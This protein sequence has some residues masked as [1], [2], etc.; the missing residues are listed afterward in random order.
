MSDHILSGDFVQKKVVCYISESW[1]SA[2][3]EVR[4][5]APLST[6]GFQVIQGNNFHEILVKDLVG[7]DYV[8]VQRDFPRN[9]AFFFDIL[10]QAREYEIPIIYEI[11]DLLFDLPDDHPDR[12]SSYYLDGLV[13]MLIAIGKAD[14]VTVSTK[15]LEKFISPFNPNTQVLQNCLADSFWHLKAPQMTEKPQDKVSIGYIG[16][17]THYPDIKMITGALTSILDQ[18]GSK[19]DL[20]FFGVTPPDEL[21]A[22]SQVDCSPPIANYREY[23]RSMLNQTIDI[24]IAPLEP[25]SFNQCKSPL[26]FLE[27]SALGVAAIFSQ[28]PPYSSLVRHEENGLL[29]YSSED[30]VRCIQML[31]ESPALRF[32]LAQN[33]QDTLKRD[34]L[35][36]QH[37]GEWK[38]I[39][40]NLTPKREKILEVGVRGERVW[41]MVLRTQMAQ[42]QQQI[43]KLQ[44][45][46]NENVQLVGELEVKLNEI[47]AQLSEKDKFIEALSNQVVEKEQIAESRV[48]EKEKVIQALLLQAAELEHLMQALS[49][50]IIEKERVVQTL[51]SQQGEKEKAAQ[52][53]VSQVTEKEL[54]LRSHLLK[55]IE[56]EKKLGSLSLEV[57]EKEQAVRSYTTQMDEL[58]Q[59]RKMLLSQVV[60]SQQAL[61]VIEGSKA[62]KIALFIR[63]IRI[64]FAPPES[65]RSQILRRFFKF[66]NWPLKKFK[67]KRILLAEDDNAV[68]QASGLFDESWYMANCPEYVNIKDSPLKHYLRIGGFRGYDPGPHFSSSWYLLTYSDVGEAGINPL[69]HYL[70]FGAAEGRQIKAANESTAREQVDKGVPDAPLQTNIRKTTSKMTDIS[71]NSFKEHLV[72]WWKMSFQTTKEAGLIALMRHIYRRLSAKKAVGPQP[73]EREETINHDVSIIIPV[74]NAASF[75]KNCIESIYKSYNKLSFEVVVVDNNST[76]ETKELLE[77]EKDQRPNFSAYHL[78]SNLGFAE[79]VNFGSNHARGNYLV[80]LNNDTLVT[81]GW[82]DRLVAAFSHNELIGIVS[83]VTNYV[84]EGPQIDPD[85]AGINVEEIDAYAETIKDRDYIYESNRLVFFCVAIKMEVW[86][87]VGNLDIGYQKGNYED[88]DYCLRTIIAGFRLAIARNVFVYHFGS[89]TFKK[90]KISHSE[91]MEQNR[92]RFYQKAQR[93]SMTLRPPARPSSDLKVSV[94]VRTLNRPKLL[95]NA[96]TSLSN[97]TFRN[98]EVVVINDG[99]QDIINILDLFDPYFPITHIHNETS[100]G[101]TVALNSG[102]NHSKGEWITFLDDDDLVYPWHLDALISCARENPEESFFY[103]DFNRCLLNFMDDKIPA[104]TIGT[105]PWGFDPKA[106]LIHN[107]T[108]IHTWLISRN[109]FDEIGGFL[110]NQDMLEDFEFLIRLSKSFDF[111][112]VNRVTCEY[113]YY[114]S[115]VNSMITQRAKTLDYLKYIY[116]Q[117]PTDDPEINYKR[118]QELA[119]LKQQIDKVEELRRELKLNPENE[120]KINRKIVYLITGI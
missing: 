58:E 23:A 76:D 100:K 19:I 105:E 34:W 50:Q 114:L 67:R 33:A 98:F 95:Q 68:I 3:T 99:G 94:I 102:I 39:Y 104:K 37:S 25:N 82:L 97:Q 62:W 26:K 45:S 7:V 21:L 79:A 110:E 47:N 71:D 56:Q 44:A 61:T 24:F 90:N 119:S 74:F 17:H 9:I 18:Y 4:L 85:A 42:R 112:H 11:D 32:K 57:V 63:R 38:N 43:E 91:F 51:L 41:E 64:L 80:V 86:D 101:R 54:E 6:I 87:S 83:P 89:M 22:Y 12:H 65:Q 77:S 66:L 107:Y 36:S 69:L 81:P 16:S 113:R 52:I 78:P 120:T 14:L 75:T 106:L 115:G 60:E 13:P 109:C 103:S 116:L 55:M 8:V 20:I 5:R 2:V 93:I 35:L 28:G 108:P 31:I 96:L 92:M 72:Y 29:A 48:I 30:W 84:G 59:A 53:L 46:V 15:A 1:S 111:F 73:Q 118:K 117:N 40:H 70:K 49:S 27:Y 88:N 10:M